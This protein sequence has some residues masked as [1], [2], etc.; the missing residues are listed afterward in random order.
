MKRESI[1]IKEYVKLLL[2]V[3]VVSVVPVVVCGYLCIVI[4]VV[5]IVIFVLV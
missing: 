1:E 5:C 3:S 2:V 4:F